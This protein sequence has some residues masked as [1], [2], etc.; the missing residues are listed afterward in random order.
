MLRSPED[1]QELSIS[2]Y[3]IGWL[4]KHYLLPVRSHPPRHPVTEEGL[5]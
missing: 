2:G 5:R 1:A 3:Q 4:A